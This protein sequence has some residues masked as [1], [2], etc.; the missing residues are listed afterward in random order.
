MALTSPR[1]SWNRSLQATSNNSP[2]MRKRAT[3]EAVRLVQQAL[4]DLGFPL[5]I[6]T[7]RYRTPDGI[8]GTETYSKVY[9]FQRAQGL[10]RDEVVGKNTMARLDALLP[11]PAPRLPPLPAAA[12]YVVPG[13]KNVIAQPDINLC[14]AT[15][16]S[17]M[18]SWKDSLSYDIRAAVDLVGTEYSAM[19]D[20]N[21]AMP[22]TKFG[23][24]IRAAGL[25]VEP[26]ANLPLSDWVTLLKLHGLL[27][28]GALATVTS[29]LHSRIVEGIRGDGSYDATWMIAS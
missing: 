13:L 21:Q 19:F 6:S 11:H 14:W 25:R 18:R 17:M 5:P 3:G 16:Y 9:A 4:I 24:F 29:G 1:F 12:M 7:K 15:A 26:M 20:N 10:G 22:P 8:Y 2:P 23:P 28:V 27:W